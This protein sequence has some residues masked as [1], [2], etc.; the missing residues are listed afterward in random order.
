MKTKLNEK[1]IGT[2]LNGF[3]VFTGTSANKGGI[4]I[5]KLEHI[6]GEDKTKSQVL[7]LRV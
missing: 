6:I 7:M 4:A 2:A 3:A 1:V 5:K